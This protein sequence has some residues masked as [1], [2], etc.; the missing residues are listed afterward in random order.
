MDRDSRPIR[1]FIVE[2]LAPAT[3]RTHLDDDDDL[4]D[5]GVVD[6]LGIFQL[7]AFLEEK[8]GVVIAD[9]EITPDNFATIAR[10]ERLVAE[11]G[12]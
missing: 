12:R 2:R 7:V 8:F 10:I 3:G 11:R 4:I 1:T 6:S 9:S 5:S